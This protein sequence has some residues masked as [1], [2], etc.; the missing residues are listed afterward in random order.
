MSYSTHT[1]PDEGRET[2]CKVL[3]RLGSI[4]HR[5]HF[6]MLPRRLNSLQHL[7]VDSIT[8]FHL[9]PISGGA[10][11]AVSALLAPVLVTFRKLPGP[12][13]P[14]SPQTLLPALLYHHPHHLH[15]KGPSLPYPSPQEISFLLP[16][17]ALIRSSS[18]A[19]GLNLPA[20]FTPC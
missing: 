4:I 12:A 10:T 3:G 2:I 1:H 15:L 5:G 6:R 11:A 13:G 16:A 9:H 18:P 8:G 14:P 7:W 17:S 20:D 19:P